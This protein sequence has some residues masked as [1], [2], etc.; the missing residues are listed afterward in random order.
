MQFISILMLL[1][2]DEYDIMML[3]WPEKF[4][5]HSGIQICDL[6]NTSPM[7]YLL[8]YWVRTVHRC[9]ALELSLVPSISNFLNIIYRN[10]DVVN[11]L[12]SGKYDIM[13]LL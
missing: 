8:S 1:Y 11:L 3:L 12:Y 7:L 6:C 10:I 4:S 5:W 13:I 2:S 9:D